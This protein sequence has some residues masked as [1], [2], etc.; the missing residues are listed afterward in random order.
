MAKSTTIRIEQQVE[1]QWQREVSVN[2]RKFK[3]MLREIRPDLFVL[4]DILDETK[5]NPLILWKVARSLNNIMI[6]N[7]YGK[8]TIEIINGVCTFIR[9]QEDD[10]VQEEV[11]KER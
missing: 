1:T 9:G 10:K 3:E 2:E 5:I 8:I 4:M 7:K 6:G 11:I